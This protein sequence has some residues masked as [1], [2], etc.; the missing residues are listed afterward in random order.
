MRNGREKNPDPPAN[1][2]AATRRHTQIRDALQKAIKRSAGLSAQADPSRSVYSPSKAE[3]A[4]RKL[5]QNERLSREELDTPM[6]IT[7]A[8]ETMTLGSDGVFAI[9]GAILGVI[10][11]VVLWFNG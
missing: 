3:A 6:M 7:L 2:R 11:V 4:I 5:R 1:R 10:L 8:N 9:G